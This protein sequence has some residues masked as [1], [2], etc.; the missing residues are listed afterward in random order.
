[1]SLSETVIDISHAG[2]KTIERRSVAGEHRIVEHWWQ[3]TGHSRRLG[4]DKSNES[5]MHGD[6]REDR[7]VQTR[8]EA[9]ALNRMGPNLRWSDNRSHSR[10]EV[11]EEPD[12]RFNEGSGH[13]YT[14]LAM[15]SPW[16]SASSIVENII[17]LI[18]YTIRSVIKV[19]THPNSYIQF[20]H[21]CAEIWK[22]SESI[23]ISTNTH[24][25][26]ETVENKFFPIAE[27]VKPRMRRF[28]RTIVTRGAND[29]DEQRN[30]NSRLLVH[31]RRE[32]KAGK[33]HS[34]H[35]H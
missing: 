9:L 24:I 12:C 33:R 4:Q 31:R 16:Q 35:R 25:L 18:N 28:A 5:G 13:R 23:E 6:R 8:G 19:T 32:R 10:S 3:S 22:D 1:M 15:Q 2:T 30:F 21:A 11:T 27:H 7:A 17:H 26:A 20:I 29:D 14:L 34:F